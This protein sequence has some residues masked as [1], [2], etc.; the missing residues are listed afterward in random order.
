M[1]IPVFRKGQWIEYEVP[2]E[3]PSGWQPFHSFQ[4]A[5]F[6]ATAHALG[7]SPKTSASLAEMYIFKQIF[8]G[9]TYDSTLESQLQKVLNHGEIT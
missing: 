8:E 9:I 5:S 6:F 7:Y 3:L 4:A 2:R 1:K